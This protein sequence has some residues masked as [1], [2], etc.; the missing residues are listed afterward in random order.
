MGSKPTTQNGR[1]CSFNVR[2]KAQ[3]GIQWGSFHFDLDLDP[4]NDESERADSAGAVGAVAIRPRWTVS[5]LSPTLL[6]MVRMTSRGQ[7]P[8]PVLK[9]CP[10]LDGRLEAVTEE[11]YSL[12]HRMITGRHSSNFG[13]R[14][15]TPKSTR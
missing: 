9:T 14:V 15:L 12:P 6:S 11:R 5:F 4:S 2:F 1:G 13:V 3:I 7:G 8:D 10:F